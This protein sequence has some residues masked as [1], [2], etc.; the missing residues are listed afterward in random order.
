MERVCGALTKTAHKQ[1]LF[2]FHEHSIRPYWPCL[3]RVMNLTTQSSLLGGELG[4]VQDWNNLRDNNERK[5]VLGALRW[6]S[7]DMQGW[8]D[9]KFIVGDEQNKDTDDIQAPTS[10]LLS[11]SRQFKQQHSLNGWF[12]L[13]NHW[14]IGA[15]A[16]YGRQD[17][18]G[19]PGFCRQGGTL[20]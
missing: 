15:E 3:T 14:S 10:R 5:S 17:G 18:D 7:A 4:I 13:D 20:Q 19:G 9:Y 16:V 1:G 6:R 2:V 12:A 11:S 8:I